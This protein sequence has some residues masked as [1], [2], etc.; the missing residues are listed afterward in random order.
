M[1]FL[2]KRDKKMAFIRNLGSAMAIYVVRDSMHSR[3]SCLLK[4]KKRSRN[5]TL[6]RGHNTT[7]VY[8]TDVKWFDGFAYIAAQ[9]DLSV[10]ALCIEYDRH[11]DRL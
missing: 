3:V 1:S 7:S 5:Y 9:K 6:F 4:L 11:V 2:G 10:W 8:P